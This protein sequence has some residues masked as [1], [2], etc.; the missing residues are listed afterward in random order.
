MNLTLQNTQAIVATEE[1]RCDAIAAFY[2][3]SA[4][5]RRKGEEFKLYK[6]DILPIIGNKTGTIK[7]GK[8]FIEYTFC[9]ENGEGFVLNISKEMISVTKRNS[10]FPD[11]ITNQI[12]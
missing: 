12:K 7:P 10:L 1:V 3:R 11:Y 5:C 9:D 2:D 4:S 8:V 6:N